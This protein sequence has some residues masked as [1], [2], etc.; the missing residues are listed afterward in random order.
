MHYA[1]ACAACMFTFSDSNEGAVPSASSKAIGRNRPPREDRPTIEART[2][3]AMRTQ[4]HGK[5]G[6]CILHEDL[7]GYCSSR[8]RTLCN[9]MEKR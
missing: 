2:C 4:C 5:V 1:L 6:H 3:L 9:L 7:L 8:G